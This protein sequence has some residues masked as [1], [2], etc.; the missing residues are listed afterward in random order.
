MAKLT[1][2]PD[3]EIYYEEYG[4]GDKH[5]ICS[6]IA[7][8]D[9]SLERELAKRGY[10]V[11]LLTNRGFGRST[12]V[13][14]NYG[15]HWYDRFADDVIAFADAKGISRFIYSGA[16]HG[17]GTGWH[18]ALSHPERMIAF[19]AVV[20]GPHNLDECRM[21]VRQQ[22][23]QGV[24]VQHCFLYETDDPS[25]LRRRDSVEE[26]RERKRA[27]PDYR[28]IYESP[29]TQSID[30]GRPMAAYGTEENVCRALQCI[31]VPVLLMG[32][33]EDTI[34]RPDLMVRSAKRLANCK[35][36]M[37]SRFGHVVDI[38]EEL[39]DEAIRF[40]D[41]VGNTG[42]VYAPVLND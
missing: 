16:S 26:A 27:D 14:E 22:L 42:R 13:T 29:E 24:S 25:L 4:F 18:V 36:V 1:V 30:Y 31:Q 3:T 38:Y 39:A 23:M 19:L 12:H 5:I 34:A 20:A 17:A 33:I 2:V 11:W 40:L 32:G 15:E 37:Y 28:E 35:L 21:S 9:E 7:H 6:Q 10:H 8:E 41:N